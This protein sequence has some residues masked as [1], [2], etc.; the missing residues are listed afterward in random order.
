M[1]LWLRWQR[2]AGHD[3]GGETVT[4]SG[5]VVKHDL[6]PTNPRRPLYPELRI[7]V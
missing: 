3:G 7:R 5:V 4:C 2:K 6:Y 1:M